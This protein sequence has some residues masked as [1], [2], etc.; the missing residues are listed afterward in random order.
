MLK[1][2]LDYLF[3]RY[4][5]NCAAVGKELCVKCETTWLA[6]LAVFQNG[7]SIEAIDIDKQIMAMSRYEN[8]TRKLLLS[9]KI[10]GNWR[11]LPI[12]SVNMASYFIN[13]I[14]NYSKEIIFVCA[15]SKMSAIRNRG[16]NVVKQ[17]GL[18]IAKILIK[19][20]IASQVVSP[21]YTSFFAKDSVGLTVEQ[22]RKNLQNYLKI[23]P[24]ELN[25]LITL[26]NT[27]KYEYIFLDDIYT[28]GSTYAVVKE[29]LTDYGIYIN[30]CL[31][32]AK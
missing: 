6:S 20:N 9:I 17:L 16:G 30:K 32:I 14:E 5:L 25:R 12:I 7:L 22:R 11:L 1:A 8:I 18:Q 19:N 21:L 13:K 2:L 23:Q 29:R 28:T 24:R 4:C 27:S 26:A 31:V 15:P 3:P 10:E